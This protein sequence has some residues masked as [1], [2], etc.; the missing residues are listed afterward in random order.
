MN[1]NT[2]LILRYLILFTSAKTLTQLCATYSRKKTHNTKCDVISPTIIVTISS[3]YFPPSV[4][5]RRLYLKIMLQLS[6]RQRRACQCKARGGLAG[7]RH[8]PRRGAG[9]ARGPGAEPWVCARS[10]G[11]AA[12]NSLLA[13]AAARDSAVPRRGVMPHGKHSSSPGPRHM[14]HNSQHPPHPPILSQLN[15][16]S[17]FS[18]IISSFHSCFYYLFTLLPYGMVKFQM[19]EL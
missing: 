1:T 2:T 17:H 18:V 14:N 13:W 12:S 5:R 4:R 11:P 9:D 8:H 19:N 16:S 6:W 15:P 7:R 10:L 3:C